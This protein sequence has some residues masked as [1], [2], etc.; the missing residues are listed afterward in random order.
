MAGEKIDPRKTVQTLREAALQTLAGVYRDASLLAQESKRAIDSFT[1]EIPPDSPYRYLRLS[2][3]D[4][5]LAYLT[6]TNNKPV[7]IAAL[8]RELEGG[9]CVFG[10][11][12]SSSEIVTKS[13][14]AYIQGGRLEWAD[15][16]KTTVR[17]PEKK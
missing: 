5:V 6:A 4:S 1:G 16:G 13:V 17:K 8:V 12:K 7:T 10:V 9:H 11:I 3:G 14:K 15:R 2:V